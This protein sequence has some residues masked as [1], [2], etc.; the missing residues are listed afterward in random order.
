[1][2]DDKKLKLDKAES[3]A[4]EGNTNGLSDE[5]LNDLK[6]SFDLFDADKDGML[7]YE[8]LIRLLECLGID[9]EGPLL[10]SIISELDLDS[11]KSLQYEEFLTMMT[12]R[13]NET[14]TKEDY[15]RVF[16]LF[17]AGDAEADNKITIK[18]LKKIADDMN[19][20]MSD[21]DLSEI[22]KRADLNKDNAVDFEEY[23][24]IMT[25]KE[26]FKK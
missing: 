22:I 3:T 12:S 26:N 9:S 18:H 17:I 25:K 20:S 5:E 1:M 16:N 23:Y 19:H 2:I 8:E 11:S 6:E 24:A 7:S 13:M 4:I 21:E 10:E 15:L 14:N